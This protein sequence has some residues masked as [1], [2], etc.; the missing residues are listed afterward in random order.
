[1]AGP[2][3]FA[4][5]KILLC[6][7][8]IVL[9]SITEKLCAVKQND[10]DTRSSGTYATSIP[11]WNESDNVSVLYVT[12]TRSIEY[13]TLTSSTA[14]YHGFMMVPPERMHIVLTLIRYAFGTVP[15]VSRSLARADSTDDD[16]AGILKI[17]ILRNGTVYNE[18]SYCDTNVFDASSSPAFL[19]R[20]TA[21]EC[22]FLEFNLTTPEQPSLCGFEVL[23]TLA[24]KPRARSACVP[25][26]NYLCRND[27]CI[28][29]GLVCDGDNNCGD[30]SDEANCSAR[31][32]SRVWVVLIC[33]VAGFAVM[34]SCLVCINYS[35]QRRYVCASPSGIRIF[36]FRGFDSQMEEP[37]NSGSS[38]NDVGTQEGRRV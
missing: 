23:V 22:I 18:S 15:C 27:I 9:L 10:D 3:S 21:R 2:A 6:S 35:L 8:L 13:W 33:V 1:M 4:R 12:Q 26:E 37:D 16:R 38:G 11:F 30:S 24:Q 29:Y 34:I 5:P 28:A 32:G 7:I 20:S 36:S 14:F 25:P 31:K 17:S 19:A